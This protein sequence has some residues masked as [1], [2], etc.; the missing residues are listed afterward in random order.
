MELEESPA[1]RDAREAL[2]V[3][4]QRAEDY[5]E[6]YVRRDADPREAL[7]KIRA[8]LVPATGNFDCTVSVRTVA[9]AV[10]CLERVIDRLDGFKLKVSYER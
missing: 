10:V 4:D 7:I 1:I 2:G 8:F 9:A 5:L 6:L 3:A